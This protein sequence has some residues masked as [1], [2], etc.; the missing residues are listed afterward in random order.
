M[1]KSLVSWAI[2]PLVSHHENKNHTL[3]LAPSIILDLYIKPQNF[4]NR[5]CFH[6]QVEKYETF[7]LHWSFT[8]YEM[9]YIIMSKQKIKHFKQFFCIHYR[10]VHSVTNMTDGKYLKQ[11]L[12]EMHELKR[13]WQL[14]FRNW[15]CYSVTSSLKQIE[16]MWTW[17]SCLKFWCKTH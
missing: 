4:G 14:I 17:E 8:E 12:Y 6:L 9:H 7:L 13:T 3:I 1:G 5:S 10:G 15:E 2:V 11:V 16:W